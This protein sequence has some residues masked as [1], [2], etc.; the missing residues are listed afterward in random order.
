MKTQD[1]SRLLADLAKAY[2][3]YCPRSA[4]MNK[5]AKHHLVDGGSHA[6]R[7]IAI[8]TSNGACVV[9]P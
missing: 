2:T 1:H 6:L 3:D 9:S 4:A 5:Q 8:H 7:L